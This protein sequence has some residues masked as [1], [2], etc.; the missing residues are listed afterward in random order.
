MAYFNKV[1]IFAALMSFSLTACTGVEG[2][3]GDAAQSASQTQDSHAQASHDHEPHDE[4]ASVDHSKY[5]HMSAIY[6]CG[7]DQLQTMHT[8]A[9]AKLAYKGQKID[10]A[11][12][13]SILDNAFVGESFKG[14]FDGQSLYFRGKGYES[15]LK[16]GNEVISCE[17]LSC[18]PLGGPH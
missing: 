7:N 18:I 8:D 2:H 1:C 14:K 10:V 3:A 15:S 13:V 16:I 11:R 4:G 17:K 12:S 5:G 9:E 6:L